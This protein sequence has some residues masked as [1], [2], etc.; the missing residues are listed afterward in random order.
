MIGLFELLDNKLK[1]IAACFQ[2]IQNKS[3]VEAS[4]VPST[5]K[6]SNGLT[7]EQKLDTQPL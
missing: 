1:P 2:F 6:L 7:S 5:Y 4:D 3:Q